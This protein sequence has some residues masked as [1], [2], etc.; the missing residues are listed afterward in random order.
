MKLLIDEM[1]SPVLARR[2]RDEY[3]AD[4]ISVLER[5]DLRGRPDEEVFEVAQLEG[6]AIVTENVPDY[7]R[8]ARNHAAAGALHH[9]LVLTTNRA[10]PRA[11]PNTIGR[12]V[13]ALNEVLSSSKDDA[14]SNR[15][16]WISA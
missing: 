7:L 1:Y 8:L 9:G 12:L 4:A 16:I 5:S 14:P 11:R 2:L 6:R 10:F 3:A 13:E 15:E